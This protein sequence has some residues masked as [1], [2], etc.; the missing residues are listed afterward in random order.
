[1]KILFYRY[2]SI[3]EN[4][5]LKCMHESGHEVTEITEEITNKNVTFAQSA[6][7]VSKSLECKAEDCVFTIN[8]YPA[9]S[10][11]C[12]IYHIRYISWIVDSPVLELF[13]KSITN[14]WNRVFL[15]DR[16]QF[17][18]IAPYNSGCIFHYPL[19]V[20]VL[21]K[22][23]VIKEASPELVKKFS[24][25]V[26]FVGSLY[27][28]KS[29][30]DKLKNAPEYLKGYLQGII[31][32]QLK[33]YGYYFVKDMLNKEIVQQFIECMPDFY[34]CPLES[35]LTDE[36]T[37]SQYYIGN[38]I[39]AVER[40]RIMKL[41]SEQMK[42][43]IYTGSDT[44]EMPA[45][46]INHGFVK[47]LTEMPIVFHESKI[48]LNP[49]SKAIRSGVPLRVFDIMAC[50]GFMISNYQI[51]MAELF[52]P[53]E[54]FVYYESIEQIPELVN[55]YLE[56]DSER[57]EIAHNAFVKVRDEF[58]YMKRLNELLL[59]AFSV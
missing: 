5:I 43:D 38:K 33:V 25:D 47:T 4:A 40:P 9:I 28:E 11:V 57:K 19:A 41:L 31:E 56:H 36:D 48:N 6:E 53:G 20:D 51:E 14:P 12:N 32:S 34:R 13:S 18:E 10:E 52:V 55:Y 39:T 15:F 2:G 58:N 29:P 44:F 22:Q 27:T 50:E 46:L 24:S 8:F 16:A 49:T 7:L 45:N 35:F 54:D 17:E 26:S 59:T 21:S 42:V 37:I 1:M 3:C 23:N 30:F